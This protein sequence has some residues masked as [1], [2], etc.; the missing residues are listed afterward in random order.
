MM[1]R[2]HLADPWVY[3]DA[4]YYYR[5]Y[6]EDN[7]PFSEPTD[8]EIEA[9]LVQRLQENP[10]TKDDDIRVDARRNVAILTGNIS[11]SLTKR[12]AGDDAWDTPGVRDVSNQLQVAVD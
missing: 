1:M 7:L 9:M 10:A 11:T 3:P 2:P 5:W 4:R 8:R 12:A 6:E